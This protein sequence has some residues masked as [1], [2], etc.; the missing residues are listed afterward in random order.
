[1][2]WGGDGSQRSCSSSSTCSHSSMVSGRVRGILKKRNKNDS[3]GPFGVEWRLPSFLLYLT[4]PTP[5]LDWPQTAA[6]TTAFENDDYQEEHYDCCHDSHKNNSDGSFEAGSTGN[7][8]ESLWFLFLQ[9]IISSLSLI[10]VGCIT[11]ALVQEPPRSDHPSEE[12]YPPS[13]TNATLLPLFIVIFMGGLGLH[14]LWDLVTALQNLHHQSSLSSSS[15]SSSFSQWKTKNHSR[16]GHNKSTKSLRFMEGTKFTRGCR[17]RRIQRSPTIPDVEEKDEDGSR[18]NSDTTTE[19]LLDTAVSSATKEDEEENASHLRS[20]EIRASARLE[21]FLRIMKAKMEASS[22]PPEEQTKTTAAAHCQ[23][24]SVQPQQQQQQQ[25]HP[26]DAL[27]LRTNRYTND[28]D[29][30]EKQQEEEYSHTTLCGGG[31]ASPSSA[32]GKIQIWL[33]SHPVNVPAATGA[34]AAAAAAA[35]SQRSSSNSTAATSITG[36]RTTTTTTTQLMFAATS[37]FSSCSSPSSLTLPRAPHLAKDENE[38]TVEGSWL[39]STAA[40]LKT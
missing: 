34:V 20:A 21:L 11:Y 24:R 28:S 19:Y 26:N 30:E 9:G 10:F 16:R 17:P 4:M 27:L 12:Q 33:G 22:H 6:A 1:M 29:P 25:H 35:G 5:D 38:D 15:S 14:Q 23:Y 18:A 36:T 32:C 13:T 7:E 37:V 40:S 3:L 39:K 31:Y 2:G 8:E